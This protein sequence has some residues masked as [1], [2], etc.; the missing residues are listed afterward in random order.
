[1]SQE[2]KMACTVKTKSLTSYMNNL[3]LDLFWT[4][5]SDVLSH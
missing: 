5:S 2:M 1:M 4:S 3:I